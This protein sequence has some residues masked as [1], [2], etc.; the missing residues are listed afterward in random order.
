M[1]ARY[2]LA[3][4]CFFLSSVITLAHDRFEGTI[5]IRASGECVEL[6][7]IMPA[8]TVAVLLKSKDNHLINQSTLATHRADLLSTA[9]AVACLLDDTGKIIPPTRIQLSIGENGELCYLFEYPV[10][11]QPVK[12]SVNLLQSLPNQ[13][14]FVVSDH[15]SEPSHRAVLVR[16]K[17]SFV[18][19]RPSPPQTP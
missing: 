1:P 13:H 19:K 2:L 8:A 4:L 17:S 12:L 7:A 11:I 10:S 14:F 15:R 9:D 16:D 6:V 18:L 3:S 5:D